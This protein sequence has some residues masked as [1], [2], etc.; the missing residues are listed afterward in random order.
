MSNEDGTV[1]TVFNG[2]IYNHSELRNDLEKRGHIFKG[3]SDTQVLT[4]LYEEEGPA[5]SKIA[6]Y[7]CCRDLRYTQPNLGLGARLVRESRNVLFARSR[8]D[9]IC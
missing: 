9:G 6:W 8:A 2:E 1:W 7:D 3:N 4:H 5:F